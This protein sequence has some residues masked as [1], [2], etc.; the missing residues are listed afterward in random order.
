VTTDTCKPAPTTWCHLW[1][2]NYSECPNDITHGMG[3]SVAWK[4]LVKVAVRWSSK[5]ALH[6][7][8]VEIHMPPGIS[9]SQPASSRTSMAPTSD[10]P[11]LHPA[12]ASYVFVAIDTV[13]S[14][15]K[16]ALD[17]RTMEIPAPI[18]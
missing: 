17:C 4:S 16:V 12:M 2:D 1:V 18:L 5:F 8:A 6:E 15:V 9:M 10:T 13:L 11:G 7:S 14:T 3:D